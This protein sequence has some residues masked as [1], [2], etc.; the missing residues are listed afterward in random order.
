MNSKKK[1]IILSIIGIAILVVAVTGVSLAFF[2]YTRTGNPNTIGT[3]RIFF[4]SSQ[5]NTL[6]LTN[7]FPL[8][9]TQAS[10]ANLDAVTVNIE[11]DT[12][13]TGGIEYLITIDQ[14]NNS[15][16]G[17]T[18][19]INF[20]AEVS[21]T[22]NIG[23]GSNDYWNA[24]ETKEASIYELTSEGEATNGKQ[25]LVGYIKS[26]T[27]GVNGTLT[28]KAYIDADKIAITDTLENGPIAETGYVNGT[29]SNWVNGRT[30]LTTTEWNSL[31]G[32]SALSFKIKAIA[33][34]GIWV[35]EPIPA[36]DSCPGCI[37][38][39]TTSYI[40]MK[41]TTTG[42]SPTILANDND[43]SNDYRSVISNS[44][45]NY[46][47]GII[48]DEGTKEIDRAFACGI[49]AE[50]PNQNTP[51]CIEG[52]INGEKHQSNIETLHSIYGS[53]DNQTQLGCGDYACVGAI[54]AVSQESGQVNVGTG[55]NSN[56]CGINN[57]GVLYCN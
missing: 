33:Q 43:Y 8:T 42:Q 44:G 13:Y 56:S 17:K 54:T 30:V 55:T 14:V 32:N 41:G 19:P 26:G 4:S 40:F 15:V 35:E 52:T 37:Y 34:E 39:Y 53:F 48:L 36:I 7:V 29:I 6:N 3:G 46:F 12:E 20:I 5:N 27:E 22:G 47:L 23:T 31:Q 10:S 24:R 18:I 50:N 51:F 38:K 16:N 28:I 1:S 49:K 21:N 57:Y 11:G 25:V 9:S 45:K 2:N